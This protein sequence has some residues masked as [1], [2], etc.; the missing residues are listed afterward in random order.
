MARKLC[1]YFD[2]HK[3]IVDTEFPIG[4]ILN[5]KEAIGRIAK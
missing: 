2:D 3:V 5:N 4:D 1:H